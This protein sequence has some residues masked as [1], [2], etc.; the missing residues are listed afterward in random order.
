VTALAPLL[1]ACRADRADLTPRHALRDALGECD[2][3]GSPACAAAL[4]LK[5][6][7][8]GCGVPDGTE[9]VYGDLLGGWHR[10]E[11]VC[12]VNDHEWYRLF[13]NDLPDRMRPRLALYHLGRWHLVCPRCRRSLIAHKAANTRAEKRRAGPNLFSGVGD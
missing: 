8:A 4:E 12:D 10:W 3:Y 1:A 13:G 2:G 6:E 7:V 9:P 11:D 5:C